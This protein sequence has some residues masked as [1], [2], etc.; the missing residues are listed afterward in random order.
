MRNY[1]EDHNL[2][3]ELEDISDHHQLPSIKNMPRKN[4][5]GRKKPGN[6]QTSRRAQAEMLAELIEQ[7]D[8]I[9]EVEFTYNATRHEREWIAN[10][11]TNLYEAQW[12]DDV[13]RQIKGGKEASVYQCLGNATTGEAFIAAKIYRPRK[14]RNLK[15]DQMYREGRQR[16]DADGTE[17]IDDGMQHA[18]NKRTTFGLQLLHT[19][20]IEHEY[21]TMQILRQAGADVPVPFTRGDNAILMTYIGGSEMAAPTLNSIKL[22]QKEAKRLFSRVLHN[23]ELMLANDR[24]HGDLSAYNILY[25]DGEITLIDFPQAIS[26]LTNRNAF[27]IFE[28]DIVR[29]SDY[30]K[31]QGVEMDSRRLAADLWT[32]HNHSL[33][34]SDVN[35]GLLDPEDKDDFAYWE[36]YLR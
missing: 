4:A 20:W 7:D 11:L 6:A 8:S 13:L 9:K 2:F 27:Q 28:R 21:K 3:E 26:P 15:N 14:F 34:P 30:F 25:W 35:L 29:M 22:P 24:I 5:S 10:S 19:S 33:A 18:M 17:I 32:A 16:L 31:Q 23:V 1:Y 36:K 12:F